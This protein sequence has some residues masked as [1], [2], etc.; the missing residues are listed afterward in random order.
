MYSWNEF[1]ALLV[2][3]EANEQ[4]NRKSALKIKLHTIKNTV[5]DLKKTIENVISLK[6]GPGLCSSI[7][8]ETYLKRSNALKNVILAGSQLKNLICDKDLMQ[9]LRRRIK[10]QEQNRGSL[11][12]FATRYKNE[13]MSCFC[14][15]STTLS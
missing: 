5:A 9:S 14:F 3:Y 10:Q 11:P 13:L 7:L 4:Y 15:N 6:C 1:Q 8:S 2:N 12:Y